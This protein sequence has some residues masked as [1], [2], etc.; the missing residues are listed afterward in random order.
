VLKVRNLAWTSPLSQDWIDVLIMLC[1][2][3]SRGESLYFALKSVVIGLKVL[4]MLSTQVSCYWKYSMCFEILFHRIE[5]PYF[6]FNFWVIVLKVL[7]MFEI[8]CHRIQGLI[9]ALTK[10]SCVEM[11]LWK[12]THLLGPQFAFH[13][14][15][16]PYCVF[17]LH[18]PMLKVFIMP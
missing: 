13:R 15:E 7:I 5:G 9:C 3:H 18:F 8:F 16:G 17:N 11:S 10:E 14:I 4:G 2:Q 6:V 1:I 12:S